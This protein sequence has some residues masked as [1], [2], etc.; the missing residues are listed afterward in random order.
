[1]NCPEWEERLAGGDPRQAVMVGDSQ[2][3][4]ATAKA[5]RIPVVA[6][7]FG[8]TEIPVAQL[9]PDRVISHFNDLLG[10]VAALLTLPAEPG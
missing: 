3:D 5:A 2:T 1:M 6:V 9:D 8:Y 10:S 4:I 7:D